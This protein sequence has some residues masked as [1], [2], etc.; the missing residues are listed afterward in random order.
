MPRNEKELHSVIGKEIDALEEGLVILRYEFALAKG[1]P[2]FLC[3]D[4]G[5]RLV[6]IEVKLQE[7]ENIVFQG[8]RYYSEIDQIRYVIAKTFSAKKINPEDTQE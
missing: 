4:S 6:I 7:D 3:V 1:T 5:G 8:L 2:D